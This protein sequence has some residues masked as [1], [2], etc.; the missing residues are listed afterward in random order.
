MRAWINRLNTEMLFDQDTFCVTY[1]ADNPNVVHQR[2]DGIERANFV[3]QW[4]KT[5]NAAEVTFD[6]K[7]WPKAG[8]EKASL[9]DFGK[10]YTFE[11]LLQQPGKIPT[12]RVETPRGELMILE[13]YSRKNRVGRHRAH[14]RL[15][16]RGAGNVPSFIL[17]DH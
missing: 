17:L 14:V 13:V 7:P 15:R 10:T 5:N 3:E 6:G 2:A 4:I 16:E 11:V 8:S 12:W 9:T 1:L